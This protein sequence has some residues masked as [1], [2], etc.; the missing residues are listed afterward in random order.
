MN[1]RVFS[2]AG[3]CL[4]LLVLS[5]SKSISA[6]DALQIKE[7]RY[8]LESKCEMNGIQEFLLATDGNAALTSYFI[9]DKKRLTEFE[10]KWYLKENFLEIHWDDNSALFGV[11]SK[12][13]QLTRDKFL[14]LSFKSINK[15]EKGILDD[16]EFVDRR[17]LDHFFNR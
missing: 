13:H 16:C 8:Y 9:K 10:G 15:D 5:I 12:V 7:N 11:S 4:F 2:I 14:Y 6:A 3:V 1:H 17:V